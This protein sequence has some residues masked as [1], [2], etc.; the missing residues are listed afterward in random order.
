ARQPDDYDPL[1]SGYLKRTFGLPTYLGDNRVLSSGSEAITALAMVLSSSL[2]GLHMDAKTYGD[3]TYD[4]VEMML[5]HYDTGSKLV[6]NAGVQGQSF[7]YD[8]FPQILFA[9]LYDLYPDTEFMREMVLNGA[10]E[11]LE[12]LPYFETDGVADYEFVG[13][14]V[15]LESPTITGGHIEPPN[16]GLAFLFYSAYVMTQNEAYLDGAKAVL[17]YFQDYQKNPN[18]EAMTDYAPLIAAILNFNHGTQYDV[19]KFL[20]F[21][22]EEDSAFRPGWS[23]MSGTLGGKQV[24]GLVGQSGD[25]AFSM[26]TFHLASV[27]APL[28]KYDARY[29]DAIGQYL[30]N[31]YQNARLFFPTEHP[32]SQQTMT[33]FLSFDLYGS[34]CYEGFRG[35]YGGV[36][37]LAMGD[38]TAMFGQPSDLSL[39]SAAFLGSYAG[40]IQ[41][42][43]N[44]GMILYDLNVTDAFG[45]RNQPY[46]LA[47][48]PS[49]SDQTLRFDGPEYAYDVFDVTHNRILARN[50][51]GTIS[52][53]VEKQSG[54]AFV[55]LPVSSSYL[56]EAG[57]ITANGEKI[58]SL[59]PAVNI[60]LPT[61]AQLTS[62]SVIPIDFQ[63]TMADP[64][65]HMQIYFGS[66]LA[67][68][69]V[70]ISEFSYDKALLPDTD[71]EIKIMVTT[72]GGLMD[73]VTKR[74]VCY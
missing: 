65:T 13:Y 53:L 6:H 22:F 63:A 57:T 21:L 16:G 28:V 9:K 20:D 3:T 33:T 46:F 26:N 10:D 38:A 60:N 44:N 67:Y 61:R 64:I 52:L 36:D 31:V 39:Y 56:L 62:S 5:A 24:S 27:L 25:Y 50:V 12:A 66:I 41:D 35:H 71:Y 69:G 1:V 29:T 54:T 47:Y 55:L 32:L 40:M 72:E 59:K 19:G 8:I 15:T 2:M 68:S 45:N 73:Y 48:N 17:D 74:V 34:I 7:W 30:Y 49:G 37:G 42:V 58:A 14:N 11:W 23:V 43:Q 4:M 51:Q 18:Y 70:P